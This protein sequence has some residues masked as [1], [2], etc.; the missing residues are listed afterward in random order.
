MLHWAWRLYPKLKSDSG[1]HDP[2]LKSWKTTTAKSIPTIY[3]AKIKSIEILD[4]LEPRSTSRFSCCHQRWG[5]SLWEFTSM[6]QKEFYPIKCRSKTWL[7]FQP[8]L[9]FT[10]STIT[11][12]GISAYFFFWKFFCQLQPYSLKVQLEFTTLGGLKEGRKR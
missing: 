12:A 9:L 3:I 6:T 11:A 2:W 1:V 10:T 8:H 7:L 5:Y 4:L